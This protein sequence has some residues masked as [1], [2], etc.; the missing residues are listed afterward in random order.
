MKTYSFFSAVV[1]FSIITF[2]IYSQNVYYVNGS[3]GTAS[4]YNS[5]TSPDSAWKTLKRACMYAQVGSDT[6]IPRAGDTVVVI[7]GV[8]NE[9]LIPHNSGNAPDSFITFRSDSLFGAKIFG[10]TPLDSVALPD[11]T[12]QL[13]TDTFWYNYDTSLT[14][15]WKR[16]LRGNKVGYVEAYRNGQRMPTSES[17]IT[18]IWHLHQLHPG[19]SFVSDSLHML[20]VFLEDSVSSPNMYS[21][22]NITKGKGILIKDNAFIK[23]QGFEVDSFALEGIQVHACNHIVIDNNYSHHN[24]R[25]GICA[26]WSNSNIWITNNEAAYNG[27][28]LGWSSGISIYRVTSPSIYVFGNSS[29]HNTDSSSFNTDGNGFIFDESA[30]GLN[31]GCYFKNNLS[32]ANQGSGIRIHRSKNCKVFNN[33]TFM[34]VCDE[35][36]I[37]DDI[38]ADQIVDSSF[39]FDNIFIE[40]N[41]FFAKPNKPSFYIGLRNYTSGDIISNYN[42]YYRNSNDTLFYVKIPADTSSLTLHDFQTL[43]GGN[44]INSFVANPLFVNKN[45]GDFHLTSTS[46]CIDTG[47][48]YLNNNEQTWITDTADQDPDGT[49][50]DM[51][52]F[53]YP[54]NPVGIENNILQKNYVNIYPNPFNETTTLEIINWINQNCELKIY[55]LYGREV[56]NYE[57]RNQKTE[58]SKNELP[59]GMYFYLVTDNKQFISSGKLIVQ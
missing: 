33:T 44:D 20:Y 54:Q 45:G 4:D 31:G 3:S 52:A 32:F 59:S 46:P 51:G 24:G 7:S 18:G 8:Y 37:C 27:A 39:V 35:M 14:N 43:T 40:N 6:I 55:D 36:S 22:W 34:N 2:S 17:V 41:I 15:V 13:D 26:N 12:W 1:I 30:D 56:R 16:P 5:G 50:L 53:Y 19:S 47:N 10:Y 21:S 23:I 48:P 28:W 25:T 58:I 11:S 29:H 49:R 9:S 42:N 38:G 57:I